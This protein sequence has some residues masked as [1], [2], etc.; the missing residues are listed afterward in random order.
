M[1]LAVI[2]ALHDI[3]VE[4]LAP[5]LWWCCKAAAGVLLVMLPYIIDAIACHYLGVPMP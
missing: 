2:R 4:L 1:I 3:L 5:A